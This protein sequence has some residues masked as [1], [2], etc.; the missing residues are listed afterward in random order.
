MEVTTSEKL[1]AEEARES[2]NR[3]NELMFELSD[4]VLTMS[5]N[6]YAL[7]DWI[8]ISDYAKRND[9]SVARVNNW[10]SR[11]VVPDGNWIVVPELNYLKLIKNQ[12]YSARSYEARATK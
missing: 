7:K 1:T 4:S 6:A 12:P 11:G 9:V 8:T 3:I 10:I 5:G 2:M